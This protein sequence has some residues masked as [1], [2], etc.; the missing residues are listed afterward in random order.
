MVKM[1]N[2]MFFIFYHNKK[3]N[4]KRK[5]GNVSIHSCGEKHTFF[6]SPKKFPKSPN[7]C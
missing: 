3:K 2:F 5:R 7:L 6:Q 4:K 1:V